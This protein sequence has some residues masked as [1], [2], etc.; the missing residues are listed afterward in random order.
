MASLW[1]RLGNIF[2]G[3]GRTVRDAVM[4]GVQGA[5][6]I[7]A[8]QGTTHDQMRATAQGRIGGLLDAIRRRGKI[9][10]DEA[11]R[12]TGSD[13]AERGL[14]EG[15]FGAGGYMGDRVGLSR[16]AAAGQTEQEYETALA[17]ETANVSSE[18]D[19]DIKRL[20][21]RLNSRGYAF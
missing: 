3:G 7:G 21:N 18:T 10:E 4:Q 14:S 17:D 20:T 1:G 2:S 12:A 6:E 16:A 8:L 5:Q 19:E 9:R 15:T 11:A 13:I